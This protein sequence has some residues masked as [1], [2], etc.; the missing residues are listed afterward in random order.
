MTRPT[1]LKLGDCSACG[2]DAHFVPSRDP[3]SW[4]REA[5][6]RL[7]RH[8]TR[9]DDFFMCCGCGGLASPTGIWADAGPQASARLTAQALARIAARVAASDG[10]LDAAETAALEQ[11]SCALALDAGEVLAM[12]ERSLRQDRQ[13]DE[14][15]LA[16]MRAARRFMDERGRL[17]MLG[18]AIQIGFADGLLHARERELLSRIAAE[19]GFGRG[20]LE[21]AMELAV[22]GKAEPISHIGDYL[23]SRARELGRPAPAD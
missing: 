11:V 3:A 7:Q 8:A 16:Q 18:L 22:F 12:T 14:I 6:G 13:D 5:L 21:I 9:A 10:R 19:L 20:S 17:L 15:F 2:T 23:D 1:L 4:W